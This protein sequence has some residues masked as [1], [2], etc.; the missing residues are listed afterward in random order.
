MEN[1]NGRLQ[2][3]HL[4]RPQVLEPLDLLFLSPSL[5]LPPSIRR[6]VEA[7]RLGGI[8]GEEEDSRGAGGLP[9]VL[10]GVRILASRSC[11]LAQR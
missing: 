1:V 11:P 8:G 10:A 2:E 5:H 9:E 4:R 6:G 3:L 7:S